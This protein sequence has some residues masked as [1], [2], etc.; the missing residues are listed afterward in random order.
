MGDDNQKIA[1]ISSFG[2][3]TKLHL[4]RLIVNTSVNTHLFT[5]DNF[6]AFLLDSLSVSFKD[7]NGDFSLQE[8]ML[9]LK[10][11]LYKLEKLS[12]KLPSR[13]ALNK[14]LS[15]LKDTFN[16][17]N[18]EF[19]ILLFL[20][21]IRQDHH[22]RYVASHLER[23]S[24]IQIIFILSQ[25]LK[26]SERVIGKSITTNS[27]LVRSGLLNITNTNITNIF[28][29]L[30]LPLGFSYQI[31]VPQENIYQLFG[32]SFRKS[33]PSKL[34]KNCFPHLLDEISYLSAY[35]KQCMLENKQ[36]VNILLCGE[37]G[38]GKTEFVRMLSESIDCET[39]DVASTRI[40][41]TA[42]A[43][44]SRMQ[45]YLI[46]Q[47]TLGT[48]AK[49]RLILFDEVEDVFDYDQ[50]FQAE[51]SVNIRAVYGG[52]CWLNSILENNI[53]PTFWVTNSI[54]E[55][56][57][58]HLR[59]FDFHLE[60]KTPP[61]ST[62]LKI[63]NQYTNE[64]P[65]SETWR[66]NLANNSSLAPAILERSSEVVKKIL[67]QLPDIP[68]EKAM[69]TIVKNS[70]A[71]MSKPFSMSNSIHNLNYRLD[72]I[73]TNIELSDFAANLT[74]DSSARLCFYGPS[75]T[76]K[77]AFAIQLATLI[78]VPLIVKRASD[79]ISP[80]VGETERNLAK[81]F[82][83]AKQEGALLL[84]DE[85][86]SFFRNR[87]Q[88]QKSWEITAVNEMLTQMECFEGLFVAT[89]NLI[90]E[91]DVAAL[92]R[93]DFKVEFKYLKHDQVA[94]LLQEVCKILS[95]EINEIDIQR[96]KNLE[97]LTPGDFFN[98]VRQAKFIPVQT[99]LDLVVRLEKEC[100]IKPNFNLRSIGF[101]A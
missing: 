53:I 92:R 78:D 24:T 77:T 36:G 89:T 75:G 84:L 10:E 30:S 86:D 88:A 35:L 79:I 51:Q 43:A 99:S 29:K 31:C 83:E 87:D 85:A 27:K 82:S 1:G 47:S 73:N 39:F 46:A 17:N 52:K 100:V 63:I 67:K 80:F 34:N 48:K 56:D 61:K 16:L 23:L 7:T 55:I 5:K 72:V 26:L 14:N 65:V 12:I 93:F 64:I 44:K 21:L 59:R 101:A 15:W 25:T 18:A 74:K 90:K 62:R 13:S 96:A 76:G 32:D 97:I 4:M 11:E 20:I 33:N 71:F 70:L 19:Q 3:L 22:L 8:L 9:N 58:A 54:S 60:I 2:K 69:N 45:S 6:D 38:T 94:V 98:I 49:K 28:D 40:D 66:N 81:V 42:I 37:P 91:I 95:I 50:K 41:G 57:N 68:A